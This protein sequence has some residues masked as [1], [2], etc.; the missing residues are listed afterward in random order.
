MTKRNPFK[1]KIN[2]NTYILGRY[3]DKDSRGEYTYFAVLI[4][5]EDG[6]RFTEPIK[7]SK[8]KWE[9]LCL[10]DADDCKETIQTIKDTAIRLRGSI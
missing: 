9:G 10:E 7:I 1:T 6:N 5:V 2:D 4:C 8:R 3:L